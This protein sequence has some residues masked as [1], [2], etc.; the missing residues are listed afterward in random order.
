MFAVTMDDG[1]ISQ[2][3]HN[4]IVRLQTDMFEELGLHF[5]LACYYNELSLLYMFIFLFSILEMP[6]EELGLSAHRKSDIETWLPAKG[7]YGEVSSL[8]RIFDCQ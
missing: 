7:F 2:E 5:R 3:M 4:E 6:S 1:K 8:C